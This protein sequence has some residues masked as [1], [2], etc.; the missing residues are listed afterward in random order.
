MSRFYRKFDRRRFVPKECYFCK[1]NKEIDFKNVSNLERYLNMFGAIQ[2][3]TRTGLC[4]KHQR[5]I[6]K[7]IKRARIVGLMPYTK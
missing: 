6:G 4:A 3:K 7:A 1:E 5:Q 2:A